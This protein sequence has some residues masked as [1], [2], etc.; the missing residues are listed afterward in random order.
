MA[1][2][3]V[4]VDGFNWGIASE[5]DDE[6]VVAELPPE[7]LDELESSALPG[8]IAMLDG[9][10]YLVN[11]DT[12]RIL[13]GNRG[14]DTIIG[15]A[16]NDTIFGG[17]GNDVI[18]GGPGNDV[19]SGD[20]GLDTLTGGGGAN[21]FM[22]APSGADR[23]VIT[24]FQPGIDTIRLP[25]DFGFANLQV[26]DVDG[27]TAVI[28]NG[29]TV[30]LLQGIVSNSITANEF[31][32]DLG[33]LEYLQPAPPD[34]AQSLNFPMEGFG[35]TANWE[36][37]LYAG[38]QAGEETSGRFTEWIS[39]EGTGSI[40]LSVPEIVRDGDTAPF[41]QP[42]ET[43]V[44]IRSVDETYPSFDL[45]SDP[46]TLEGEQAELT[47]E[48]F[49]MTA[50][51]GGL[52]HQLEMTQLGE[53]QQVDPLTGEDPNWTEASFEGDGSVSS[54]LRVFNIN[55]PM[56]GFGEMANWEASLYAGPQAGEETSGRFT[57]WISAEGTGSITLSVPE[58]VRDGDT[59]P[60]NQPD[61]TYVRI[62]SVDETYPSFDLVSDPFTLEGEQ[63]ELTLG[64]L[65]LNSSVSLSSQ[66][67]F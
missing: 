35:E 40:T 58:I 48:S 41:N 57:E 52:D 51:I 10:D 18:V 8:A 65:S 39:A 20:R 62:R 45:V 60:F 46:F 43:Y 37:S 11:N 27:S 3:V 15:G 2:N 17:Q 12:E 1:L 56:E 6:V 7:Q 25:D 16:G 50:D 66:S 22:M 4:A 31:V 36:A 9:N 44:R 21:Q 24:D 33:D 47:L 32:G 19:L 38:P 5:E 61:E 28:R 59:A 14:D 13:F 42:D 53:E 29:E 30:T 26:Q 54:N 67:G 49:T 63:A 64:S 55:F 34:E 23:D